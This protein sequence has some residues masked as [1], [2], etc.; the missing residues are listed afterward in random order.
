MVTPPRIDIAEFAR[1]A[2]TL[3]GEVEVKE[4]PRLHDLIASGERR[5][6]YELHGTCTP[7]REPQIT[8]TILGLVSLECQRCLRP[9]DLS[10]DI[11]SQL[12]FVGDET[13]LPAIEDEGESVDY[14]VAESPLDVLALI[15]DEVILALPLV[16][17]HDVGECEEAAAHSSKTSKLSPFATL[18]RVKPN[19]K[20]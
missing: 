13:L 4:L 8:C 12:V 15:E 6:R 3:T 16:P 18:A 11:S 10:L 20:Q 9:F 14:V 2:K 19:P 5:L 1:L 7:R 17:R